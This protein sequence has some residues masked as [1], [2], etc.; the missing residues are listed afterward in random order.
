ME[1]VYELNNVSFRY[2]ESLVL[3]NLQ[4]SI[5][6]GDFVGIVGA[7][8]S[9]K[10][11]LLRLLVGD[12]KPTAG[13]MRLF[14]VDGGTPA[15]WRRVGY[16]PQQNPV[17]Q[18]RF[19]ISC[20][21][22][23]VMPL[24]TNFGW[25]RVPSREHLSRAKYALEEMGLKGFEHRDYHTLSGGQKQRVQI[26]KAFVSDPDVLIFDEPTVGID[27]SNKEAFFG[28]LRH[29]NEKHDITIVMVTHEIHSGTPH[30]KRTLRLEN[31][32]LVEG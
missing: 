16:V 14:G 4:L 10:T 13:E 8:G 18:T 19:P 21:E 5:T 24:S 31:R 23:A 32:R 22:M 15:D 27:E 29:L 25:R 30:W 9:G 12:L 7:N 2:D 17:N 20:L 3:E 11:T 6:Q 28:V 1:L 26:A